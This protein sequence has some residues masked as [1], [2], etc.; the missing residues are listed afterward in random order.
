MKKDNKNI[1]KTTAKKSANKS[2][3]STKGFVKNTKETESKGWTKEEIK[4]RSKMFDKED[5]VLYGENESSLSISMLIKG[6]FLIGLYF[7]NL[8]FYKENVAYLDI[9]IGPHFA[10]VVVYVIG[11]IGGIFYMIF[12]GILLI[13]YAPF[14]EIDDMWDWQSDWSWREFLTTRSSSVS[15]NYENIDRINGYVESKARFQTRENSSK[16]ISVMNAVNSIPRTEEGKRALGYIDSKV[17]WMSREN[18]F[19][20]IKDRFS[21]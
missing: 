6:F 18:G 11:M 13:G 9:F 4:E 20:F 16:S 12:Y 3:K 21:K 1:A 17:K 19:N 2:S 14:G 7:F 5:S 15:S 8:F 10:G